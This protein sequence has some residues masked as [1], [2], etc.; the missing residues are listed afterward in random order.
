M[1]WKLE[2][3][4]LPVADVDRAREFYEERV[5]FHLDVDHRAGDSF[6]VVQLTPHGSG[7]SISFGVGVADGEPGSV[8]GLHLVVDDIERAH[9]E[10]ASRG[11]ETSGIQHFEEGRPTPGPHPER[12]DF[13]SYIFFADPDGNSWAVQEV[14]HGNP[15][16]SS[17]ERV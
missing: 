17:S 7:C 15:E 13:G 8:K 10:L 12:A 5:G 9:S 6:R 11:V 2:V 14:R 4:L 3:V 1:D 16:R